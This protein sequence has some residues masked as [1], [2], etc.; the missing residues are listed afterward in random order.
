MSIITNRRSF[1]FGASVA[2]FGIFAPGRRGWAGGVGPNEDAEHRLHRRRRQG[3][4]ATPT[5]R[6][7]SAG[8]SRSATSTQKRLGREGARSPKDAKKYNDFR[9]LLEEL[10]PKIDAVVVSTP[11][12]THAAAAVM[13]MRLGKHVYCQKPLAHSPYEARLMRETAARA[14][15]LHPDGQPGD[16]PSRASA[17]GSS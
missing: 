5:T 7:H 12:H 17:A 3:A 8:S 6:P 4:R 1:L 10:G 14:E 2:G 15:G 13:A 11:D 16:G 9:K